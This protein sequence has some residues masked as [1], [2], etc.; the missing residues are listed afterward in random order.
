MNRYETSTP[1]LAL[2]LT[3]VALTAITFSVSVVMPAQ[4][5]SDSREAG[6]MAAPK[7]IA[8]ARRRVVAGSAA[9]DVIAVREAS[10]PGA[11]CPSSQPS[12]TPEG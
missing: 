9:T 6:L 4:T 3:A 7:I 11:P 12:R 8:P 10:L 5:L 1:R 2:G